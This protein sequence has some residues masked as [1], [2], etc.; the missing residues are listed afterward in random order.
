MWE[1]NRS[2]GISSIPHR[3][4]VR[5]SSIHFKS[6]FSQSLKYFEIFS[7]LPEI[8]LSCILLRP[9]HRP[10]SILWGLQRL[11]SFRRVHFWD[12]SLVKSSRNPRYQTMKETPDSRC[13]RKACEKHA[14]VIEN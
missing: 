13:A 6:H 8:Q 1:S 11:L 4:C 2:Q 5:R 7:D 12:F 14:K 9:F 10:S 3:F